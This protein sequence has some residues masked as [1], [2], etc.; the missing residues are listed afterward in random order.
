MQK[1]NTGS[2]NELTKFAT[3]FLKNDEST[4][5]MQ[6]NDRFF[7]ECDRLVVF[8]REE[9]VD[10]QGYDEEDDEYADPLAAMIVAFLDFHK[11]TECQITGP[12]Y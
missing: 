11:I 1:T 7:P 5:R 8:N 3:D 9:Y 2:F 4:A 10:E 6:V 12:E